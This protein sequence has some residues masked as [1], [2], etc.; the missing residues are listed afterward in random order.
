MRDAKVFCIVGGRGT[1]KTYFLE[2]T[3]SRSN[4]VVF[5]LVKTNRWPDYEKKFYQDFEAGRINYKE[6]ANK[7]IVFEDATSYVNS[8]MKNSLKQLIV[9]SKQLGS[10]VFVVF[11]SINIIPPFM[12]N[13]MN[14]IEL[15]NCVKPRETAINAD[16]YPEIMRKWEKLQ[17]G[18]RY[19]HYTIETQI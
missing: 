8:N 6:I 4:T 2:Q 17:K 7:K 19:L 16:Y 1:G 15:F 11:H 3:L 10:D 12:W 9:Y 13:M 5:E 18:K 14:Y